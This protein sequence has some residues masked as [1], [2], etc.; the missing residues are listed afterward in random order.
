M[1]QIDMDK[2][3]AGFLE[4]AAD[5]LEGANE[6]I[7]RAESEGNLELFNSVFRN[8]HT[9]KGTAGGLGFDEM[10]DFSHHL[11]TILDKLR[12]GEMKID[13]EITDLL[14]RGVDV[15]FEMVDYARDGKKYDKDLSELIARYGNTAEE[16]VKSETAG[17]NEVSG[18]VSVS[19]N[20]REL[21]EKNHPGFGRPYRIDVKFTDEMLENGYDPLTL[22]SNLREISDFFYP[23][24]DISA[25]PQ[26]DHIEPYRLY[27]RP[28]IYIISDASL[29][30]INDLAFDPE[31]MDVCGISLEK[32]ETEAAVK[33]TEASELVDTE[34]ID[35]DMLAELAAGVEDYFESIENYLIEIE[36]TGSG[37]KD[38]VDNIFRV[39]HNIKGDSGYV[40]F[41]FMEKYAHLVENMLDK[42][43][44]GSVEFDKKAAE[45]ILNVISDVKRIV[46]ELVNGEDAKLPKTYSMLLEL[47]ESISNH[48]EN[49]PVI[50]EDVKVFLGQVDQ[51]LEMIDMSEDSASG[52][53]I[54][55]RAALGLK[56][57][58]RFIGFKDLN[59]LAEEFEAK[60]LK[61]EDHMQ[62]L[63]AI[64]NYIDLLKSPP[65]KL[66]ELL[67]DSGKV[68]EEEIAAAKAQQKKIGEILVDQGKLN[69]ED[70]DLVLK[71]QDI[72]KAAERTSAKDEDAEPLRDPQSKDKLPQSMKV[73]QE[74]IDKFT[75]TIGE[76]TVAKNAYEYMVQK[77]IREYDL[78]SNLVKDFKDNSNLISRISQDLQRDILSLRMVPIRQIFNKFPRVVR[79]IS[80]KQNKQIALRIIGEDTEIDK[81]ISDILSDPLVHLVRNACDHGL[82]N[83]QDREASGKH[84]EGTLILKAYNEGS[85]VYIEVI[86]DGKGIDSQKVLKKAI[87]RG[88]VSEDEEL[89]EKEIIQLI[90]APGLS[91]ADKVTD[92]SGRGVGMDVVKSSITTV[93]GFIDVSSSLGEGTRI[94]MK[95]PVTIGMST[96]LLVNMGGEE[97]YAF[98]IE[99]VAET[100]KVEKDQVKDLH[101]GKGIY[102]RGSVLP[103]FQLT[104]LLGGQER[105]LEDEVNIVITVTDAG[106]TGI[107]VDELMNRMDIAIK[108][109]PEY[110]AHL[111]Y[112]GG[113]TILGDGQAVL[114]LNVNKLF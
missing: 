66:G 39:F 109:V 107:I 97:Y 47:S 64:I 57:A 50:T 70:L 6:D 2:F 93:G 12:N 85:F 67:V 65:K 83:T 69:K 111:N 78:P 5:L 30:E 58:A 35:R 44:D 88:M 14:L 63:S 82:E 110:F 106:K 31:I 91:T 71:R 7:L 34:G 13:G 51:F 100:I 46:S 22:Y 89:S 52:N 73:D 68:T 104:A 11:E 103:L 81:K 4:E 96:S 54:L 15:L 33:V 18:L 98:P 61:S 23:A 75:N 27:L 108:P 84:S 113:V 36:K 45:F 40:G 87:S 25:V 55:K 49:V 74:K 8:I 62:Q 16:A 76:L 79:D 17:E 10:T 9:I 41:S 72:M 92:I 43:R 48:T 77:L 26:I 59:A 102:Y 38:A 3:R 1:T 60:V 90:L 112:I 37:S 114:V 80:R 42:V 19:E 95:I 94:T 28:E 29:E 99:N 53:R 105:E 32:T 86:D 20:I 101:F 24:A 56:N 21:L